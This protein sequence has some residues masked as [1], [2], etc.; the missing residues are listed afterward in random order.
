MARVLLQALEPAVLPRL[1]VRLLQVCIYT[2]R[3]HFATCC[4]AQ[5]SYCSVADGYG[6]QVL[7][8]LLVVFST[9]PSLRDLSV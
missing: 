6:A 1:R 2:P 7:N 4:C 9:S 5:D 8:R 3:R